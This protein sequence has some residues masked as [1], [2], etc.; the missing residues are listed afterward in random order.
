MDRNYL[1][2]INMRRSIIQEQGHRVHGCMPS[3][4]TAVLE[5]Y[6]YLMRD[7]LPVRYP[8]IFKL[9]ENN[10]SVRN[11]ATRLE[12]PVNS[13]TTPEF[14]A[15]DPMAALRILGETVEDDMF[16]LHETPEGHFTS[17]FVC[18]FPAGFDPS[19]KI[20]ILL[21]D[22]HGPVPSY[23]KIESSMERFFCKLEVGKSVKR[24]NV[25]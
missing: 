16:I 5:I 10:R 20:G 4:Q 18:C 9:S 8:T 1:D 21:K 17:A 22:V 6:T 15:G 23:E 3:G 12:F 13:P 25:G 19:E 2:R 7:Y 11:E 24:T 14:P